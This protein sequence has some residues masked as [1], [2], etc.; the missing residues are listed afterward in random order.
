MFQT[1]LMHVVQ[2][3]PQHSRAA[4]IAM[5][6][7][8]FGN[9]E[10]IN[11]TENNV[12]S[13]AG[14]EDKDFLTLR[15]RWRAALHSRKDNRNPKSM[16]DVSKIERANFSRE[17]TD[18]H[19]PVRSH[20]PRQDLYVLNRLSKFSVHHYV[21]TREQW[22]FRRDAR[23]GMKQRT[24]SRFEEYNQVRHGLDDSVCGWLKDFCHTHGYEQARRWLEGVGN[25]SFSQ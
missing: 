10:D 2:Q 14:F 11:T 3:S 18:A 4:C 1:S 12:C 17:N 9:F 19:R 5:P 25:V 20:C 24:P 22:S 13:P 8:R 15:W 16:I 6:R 23:E 7:V 21:G